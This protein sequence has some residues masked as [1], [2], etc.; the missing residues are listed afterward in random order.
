MA[1]AKGIP[2]PSPTFAPVLRPSLSTEALVAASRGGASAHCQLHFQVED[3]RHSLYD[4]SGSTDLDAMTNAPVPVDDDLAAFMAESAVM[5]VNGNPQDHDILTDAENLQS[6]DPQLEMVQSIPDEHFKHPAGSRTMSLEALYNLHLGSP[7]SLFAGNGF[8][9]DLWLQTNNIYNRIFAVS[10]RDASEARISDRGVIFKAFE[11]GWDF[12]SHK[13][14]NNPVIQILR[15]YDNLVSKCLDRV[16]RLA[17]AYKNHLLIQYFLNQD[18]RVLERMPAW[19]RPGGT[20]RDKKYPILIDFFAWPGLRETLI[21]GSLRLDGSK[22]SAAYMRDFRFS[23]PF[24]LE[25][26]YEYFPATDTYVASPLF[27]RYHRDL[28]F[29]TMEE[30]FFLEF[31]EFTGA[32]SASNSRPPSDSLGGASAFETTW[33]PTLTT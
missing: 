28:K 11:L 16:N 20:K 15:C 31:P 26:T 23:W 30:S 18:F 13:E 29:W 10:P 33:L 8:N 6:Q 17:I 14:Q 19:Q 5:L 22:F 32:M 9:L 2:I 1:T 25:D 4:E 21:R 12:L 27:E 24:S 7:L 3:H